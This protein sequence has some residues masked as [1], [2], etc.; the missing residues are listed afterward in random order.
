MTSPQQPQPQI[1]LLLQYVQMKKCLDNLDITCTKTTVVKS[2]FFV[3]S[4]VWQFTDTEFFVSTIIS[5]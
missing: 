4:P 2:Q 5:E 1:Q 3:W